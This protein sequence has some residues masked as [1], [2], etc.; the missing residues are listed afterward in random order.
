MWIF[1]ANISC[2]SNYNVIYSKGLEEGDFFMN[3]YKAAG[4]VGRLTS[5]SNHAEGCLFY[6]GVN[7]PIIDWVDKEQVREYMR[8]WRNKN[9]DNINKNHR[10]W[11]KLN[12]EKYGD[13]RRAQSLTARRKYPWKSSCNHAKDRCNNPN[14]KMYKYYGGKGVK[15]LMTMED[16]K[17]LWFRDKAYLMKSPTIDRINNNGHYEVV[18]CEYVERS[19]NSGKESGK[20]V[21]QYD[22]NGNFIRKFKS[23]GKA[24]TATSIDRSVIG[25]CCNKCKHRKTAGGYKWGFSKKE[26]V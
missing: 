25:G 1:G 16:F 22:L 23:I 11:Y 14:N 17:K 20:P 13:R 24:A 15:F 3:K 2:N 6:C 5:F 26:E 4:S 9:R 19:K 18:N 10:K 12:R 7:M 8:K 21:S